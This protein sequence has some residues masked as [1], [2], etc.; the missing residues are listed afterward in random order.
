MIYCIDYIDLNSD[1]YMIYYKNK[2]L[3]YIMYYFILKMKK[4]KGV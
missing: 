3:E 4:F 2:M 1:V